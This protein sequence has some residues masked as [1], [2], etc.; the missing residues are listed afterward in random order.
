MKRTAAQSAM[1]PAGE[2]LP[3]F[4]GAAP[5][6]LLPTSP[7]ATPATSQPRLFGVCPV[8]LGTGA[9]VVKRGQPARP[10]WCRTDPSGTVAQ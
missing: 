4:S 10:C 3:L 1:F 9:V 2:D 5:R 7:A 6:A 8:C